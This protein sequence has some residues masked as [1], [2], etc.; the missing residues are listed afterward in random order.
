MIAIR[1]ILVVVVA[2][3]LHIWHIHSEYKR[4]LGVLVPLPAFL[5][6]AQNQTQEPQVPPFPEMSQISISSNVV[7]LC[8]NASS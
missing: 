2:I 1:C 3:F 6:Q 5:L 4:H 7:P 8:L